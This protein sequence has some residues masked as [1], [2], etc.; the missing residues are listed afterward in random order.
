LEWL[1]TL[2]EGHRAL[3]KTG[4][5]QSFDAL[6]SN[7]RAELDKAAN[8][9]AA[10]GLSEKKSGGANGMQDEPSDWRPAAQALWPGVE[11]PRSFSQLSKVAQQE[12]RSRFATFGDT[13]PNNRKDESCSIQQ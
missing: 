10:L 13:E 11:L 8:R 1:Y 3:E 5:R 6:L 7:L 12:V 2:P 9:R 4:R